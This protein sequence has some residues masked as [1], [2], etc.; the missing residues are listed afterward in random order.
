MDIKRRTM[1][2]LIP[3]LLAAGCAPQLMLQ[4]YTG[5]PQPQGKLFKS[6]IMGGFESATQINNKG[7]RIDM[8]AATNHDYQVSSDYALLRSQGILTA[9]DGVRWPKIDNMGE[10]DF[11]SFTPMLDAA[12]KNDMQVIWTLCHYGWPDDV[13]VFSPQFIT[14]FAQYSAAVARHVKSRT[15]EIPYYTPINEIS[16]LCWAAGEVGWIFPYEKD[17]GGVLKRQLVKAAIACMDAIWEVDPRARFV[18]VDPVINVLPKSNSPYQL[19]QARLVNELQFEASDMLAGRMEP[20]LGGAEKYLDIMGAN[21]YSTNQW[22]HIGRRI[23]W[24]QGRKDKRWK[25]LNELLEN[26]Y[27]RYKRPMFLGETSNVGSLRASWMHEITDEILKL[28]AKGVPFEGIC[29]YPIIDRPDWENFKHW[30]NSGLWDFHGAKHGL[31]SRVLHEPYA[32]EIHR[33]QKLFE[34]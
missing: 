33:A 6:F 26:L 22:A 31:H 25:P 17:H 3:G 16:F 21:F 7:N 29:L 19:R 18:H 30:H 4:N 23:K 1:L 15:N 27:K 5:Q 28:K 2:K 12:I 11:S 9:R 24:H 8:I 32:T 20:E 14:R 34:E 10:Y 13:D